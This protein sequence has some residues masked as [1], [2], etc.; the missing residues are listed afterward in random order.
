MVEPVSA[1]L[2]VVAD[3]VAGLPEP[4]KASFFKAV[5]DL[6]GGLTAVP[7]AKLKQWAQGIEDTT[8]AKSMM[9]AVV[10]KAAADEVAKDPVLAQAAAE[11]FLPTNL[12]KARNRLIVAQGAAERLAEAAQTGASGDRAAPPDDD[13]MN[14]FARFAEDASSARLQDLFG[15]IL[16]GE[17]FR[18]GAYG[19]ATLRAL[20][21]LDQAVANDFAFAWAKSV[22]E[23]VDYAPEWRRGE[24][25]SRWKRLSDAGLM[26]TTDIAQYLPEFHP[27]HNG[28]ALWSPMSAEGAWLLVHFQQGAGAQ[29]NHIEFTRVGRELGSLL[30]RPDYETNMRN[31]AN[32]LPR[33]GLTR[34]ELHSSRVPVEV[35]WQVGQ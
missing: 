13:W 14:R 19:L 26:A 34:I 29:W 28:Q 27:T 30:E 35:I 9:S 31:A 11:V 8:A 1:G 23:A 12:R 5:G 25:F 32:R 15:R 22:G 17:I 21:E 16:A 2:A 20:S 24:A 7:A 6:L 33:G 18:P 3:A 4:I 10:A